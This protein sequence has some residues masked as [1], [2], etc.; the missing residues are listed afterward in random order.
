M[1]IWFTLHE[2]VA[3]ITSQGE[4]TSK[5]DHWP[6]AFVR[7]HL[8]NSLA[9]PEL[10]P[11]KAESGSMAGSHAFGDTTAATGFLDASPTTATCATWATADAHVGHGHAGAGAGAGV[12]AGL[13][14]GRSCW[15][16][17]N[18]V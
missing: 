12:K 13:K 3:H 8:P 1:G 17:F 14:V 6:V 4:K 15:T 11:G 5:D 16:W 7:I 18:I 9:Q 2:H 10:V